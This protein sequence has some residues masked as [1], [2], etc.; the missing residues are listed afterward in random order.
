MME[1]DYDDEVSSSSFSRWVIPALVVSLALHAWFLYW[2]YGVSLAANSQKV[3]DRLVPRTFHVDRVEIDQKLLEPEPAADKRAA[4]A[5]QAVDLPQEKMAFEKLMADN[6]GEPAAPK[7]DQSFLSDKPTASSTTFDKTMQTAQL[8]GAQSA[9]EDPK[10]LQQALLGDRPDAG[11]KPV[12]DLLAP[13]S[14]TGRAIVKAGQLSGGDTPGFSNLDDLLAQ[15][16]PL[17]PGTAPIL[18]PSDLLFEYGE[19]R[20]NPGAMAGLQK[21]GLLIRR[22]PQADFIIEGHTDSFGSDDSNMVLSQDRATM[23]KMWLVREMQIAPER[24][25]TRGYGKTRLI[26]PG[27]GTVEEQQINRRVEIVIRERSAKR[28]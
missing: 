22:N 27:S 19:Y 5:P 9:L 10:A 17:S 11:S 2:A 3:Y 18:M 23:V 8:T 13:D 7:I 4:L 6:K 14:L 16:G 1:A 26:A 20:L 28:P 24:I 15:T 21:L 12:G 25:E